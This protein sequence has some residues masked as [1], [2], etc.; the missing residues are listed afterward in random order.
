MLETF[1]QKKAKKKKIIPLS[2]EKKT[3]AG[4]MKVQK[5]ERSKEERKISRK[6]L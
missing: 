5:K 1:R 6:K 4:K 2:Q 3:R